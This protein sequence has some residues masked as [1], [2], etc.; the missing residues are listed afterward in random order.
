MCT[1]CGISTVWF[2]MGWNYEGWGEVKL[3]LT[4]W[5]EQLGNAIFPR[6]GQRQ[7]NRDRGRKEA[8]GLVDMLSVRCLAK[9]NLDTCV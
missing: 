7:R 5:F 1:M 9:Q 8:T 4:C 6:Q 2:L 3:I